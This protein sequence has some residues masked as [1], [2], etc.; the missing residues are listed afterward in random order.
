MSS[1][2]NDFDPFSIDYL[3][4]V[5]TRMVCGNIFSFRISF[6][7]CEIIVERH[8]GDTPSPVPV[9]DVIVQ[10]ASQ[11]L[12]KEDFLVEDK[13]TKESFVSPINGTF[14]IASSPDADPFVKQG[15]VVE[16]GST[17]CI[18]EAMKVMNEIKSEKQFTID[19]ILI[20]DGEKVKENQP[21]FH[22][23]HL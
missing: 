20:L 13:T 15:E 21:I 6:G 18:I 4:S 9:S 19:A 12:K 5:Y 17:L 22:I 8:F 2:S 7:D 3:D 11:N 16:V 10:N 23:S 1:S 14:Y